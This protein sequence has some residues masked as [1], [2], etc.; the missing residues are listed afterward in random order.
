MHARNCEESKYELKCDV[1]RSTMSPMSEGGGDSHSTKQCFDIP[2]PGDTKSVPTPDN[3]GGGDEDED[4]PKIASSG[5]TS[6]L[7]DISMDETTTPQDTL[8]SVMD[9]TLKLPCEDLLDAEL[10]VSHSDHDSVNKDMNEQIPD[11]EL[12]A[13]K[14]TGG[15]SSATVTVMDSQID[16]QSRREEHPG[17]ITMAGKF[18][19]SISKEYLDLLKLECFHPHNDKKLVSIFVLHIV[20]TLVAILEI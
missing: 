17:C 12:L 10:N 9:K 14:E 6:I 13:S 20:H 19:F 2:T 18:Y 11:D 1:F 16:P 5:E 3:G 4:S 7:G 8:D 15:S